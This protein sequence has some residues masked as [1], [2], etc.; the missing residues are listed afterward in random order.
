MGA[1]SHF[2]RPTDPVAVQNVRP[3]SRAERLLKQAEHSVSGYRS[4]L[5]TVPKHASATATSKPNWFLLIPIG[6]ASLVLQESQ[7]TLT[8]RIRLGS[9]PNRNR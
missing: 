2:I 9:R 5:G 7:A 6:P 8:L 3:V 1:L 4:S